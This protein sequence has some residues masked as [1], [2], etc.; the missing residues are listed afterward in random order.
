MRWAWSWFRAIFLATGF[1]VGARKNGQDSQLGE[2]E[3]GLS[4][5]SV[6]ALPLRMS[7]T[8][9]TRHVTKDLVLWRQ[10]RRDEEWWPHE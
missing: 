4:G 3:I 10:G 6:A 5:S 2:V 9:E 1:G 7:P 8:V